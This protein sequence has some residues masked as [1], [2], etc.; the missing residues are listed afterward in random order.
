MQ[1]L[2]QDIKADDKKKLGRLQKVDLRTYWTHEAHNFT[3]WLALEENIALLTEAIGIDGLEVERTEQPVGVFCADIVCRDRQNRWVVIENQLEPTNHVHLGQ[4]LTY[5][6]GLDAVTII[7]VV[8]SFRP[9]HRAAIDWLNTKIPDVN[10]F[11]VEVELWRIGSSDLAPKFNVVCMP[12]NWVKQSAAAAERM[13]AT[14]AARLQLEYW[15]EFANYV[16]THSKILRPTKPP[17]RN[18]MPFAI[19]TTGVQLSAD[20]V[21]IGQ[22]RISVTLTVSKEYFGLLIADKDEIEREVGYSLEWQERPDIESS[23]LVLSQ[24]SDPREKEEWTTQ[25]EWLCKGLEAF[26]RAFS[27]RLKSMRSSMEK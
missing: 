17:P 2:A 16:S 23:Y 11:G 7:W 9:E 4:I 12:N 10:F 14:G 3:P 25:H 8:Q 15:T 13:I 27:T 24:N 22:P 18:W 21:S 5:A 19:G 6:A 1:E 20:M 26:H